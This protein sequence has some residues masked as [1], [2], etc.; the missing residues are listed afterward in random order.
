MTKGE[1]GIG[2]HWNTLWDCPVKLE[3]RQERAVCSLMLYIL[4]KV[5]VWTQVF[6]N[7]SWQVWTCPTNKT[8]F[9]RGLEHAG[10]SC[11]ATFTYKCRTCKWEGWT[12]FFH[13]TVVY[14]QASGFRR[15]LNASRWREQ[16]IVKGGMQTEKR[17]WEE[18]LRRPQRSTEGADK[19]RRK[20]C[21]R[22]WLENMA[23]FQTHIV[24][25]THNYNVCTSIT[26][27]SLAIFF[28]SEPAFL[29]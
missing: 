17:R 27:W 1:Q 18:G 15:P 10:V 7:V 8:Y 20:L 29:K 9:S 4:L 25:Y 23:L 5:T 22:C 24:T 16:S 13:M 12:V 26:C 2:L 19:D 11:S 28:L 6:W 14:G 21:L 3:R